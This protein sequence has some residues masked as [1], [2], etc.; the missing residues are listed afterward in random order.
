MFAGQKTALDNGGW[1]DK[2]RSR[3]IYRR[4]KSGLRKVADAKLPSGE[5]DLFEIWRT[6]EDLLV[7]SLDGQAHS[8][9]S[10]DDVFDVLIDGPPKARRS[11]AREFPEK[12]QRW[13][14]GR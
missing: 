12:Y 1:F 6:P 11:A 13:L 5:P 8:V 7:L 9:V 14:D 10:E 4:T 3:L 2:R